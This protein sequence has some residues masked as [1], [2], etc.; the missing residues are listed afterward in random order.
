MDGFIPNIGGNPNTEDHDSE[1]RDKVDSLI[2]NKKPFDNIPHSSDN[3][4]SM[5]VFDS[6]MISSDDNASLGIS[7]NSLLRQARDH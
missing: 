2:I 4:G 5:D 6:L 7:Q 3:F 1:R